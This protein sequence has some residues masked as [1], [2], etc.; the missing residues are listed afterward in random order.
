MA[1]W[2]ASF[3]VQF[4]LSTREQSTRY[5]IA[6]AFEIINT[7]KRSVFPLKRDWSLKK[8]LV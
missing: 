4:I 8:Y 7:L 1:F 2:P 5:K 3:Q 6:L